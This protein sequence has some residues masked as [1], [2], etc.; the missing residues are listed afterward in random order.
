MFAPPQYVIIK[1]GYLQWK[2]RFNQV[3][4]AVHVRMDLEHEW[5]LVVA[6]LLL[7]H[8]EQREEL[9]F[10]RN[11]CLLNP[12]LIVFLSRIACYPRKTSKTYLP[13]L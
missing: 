1:I 4:Y 13:S 9:D 7:E 10:A 6:V 11:D 2:G 5:K 12:N 3:I 8:V